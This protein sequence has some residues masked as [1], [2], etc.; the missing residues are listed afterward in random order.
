MIHQ[1]DSLFQRPENKAYEE[2]LKSYE[3]KQRT[4]LQKARLKAQKAVSCYINYS[5]SK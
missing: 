3:D 4:E 5:T 1:N 2:E